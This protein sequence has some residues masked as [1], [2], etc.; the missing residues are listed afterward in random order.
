MPEKREMLAVAQLREP[1]ASR[2]LLQAGHH[3][4]RIG[5]DFTS[6]NADDSTVPASD[7]LG[8]NNE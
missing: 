6:F 3:A 7:A 5:I 4:S 2:F 1:Y 8:P